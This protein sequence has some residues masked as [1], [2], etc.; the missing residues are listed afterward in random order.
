MLDSN[1]IP[2]IKITQISEVKIGETVANLGEIL[3]IEKAADFYSLIIARLGEKQVIKFK[4]QT[5]LLI[6]SPENAIQMDMG[7]GNKGG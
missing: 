2:E 6:I 1:S 5:F 3:E 7:E 4:K